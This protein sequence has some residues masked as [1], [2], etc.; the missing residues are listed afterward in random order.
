M[1]MYLVTITAPRYLDRKIFIALD[2]AISYCNDRLS[3]NPELG[4]DIEELKTGDKQEIK[5]I[6]I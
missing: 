1:N 6:R 3:E 2:I 5:R 4:F